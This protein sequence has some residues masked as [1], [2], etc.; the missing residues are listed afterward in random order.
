MAGLQ[1]LGSFE[2][3]ESCSYL[4]RLALDTLRSSSGRLALST[5]RNYIACVREAVDFTARYGVVC[6][7]VV[8]EQTSR[9]CMLFFQHLRAVGASWGTLR[10]VRSA[11]RSFHKALGW[12][13]PWTSFPRLAVMTKGLQKQT[14]LPPVQKAGL[15]IQMIKGILDYSDA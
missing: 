12:P 13:D 9:G 8:N 4:W 1:P 11:F 6:F 5:W 7:P 14:S 15:T 10:G 2:E 3:D